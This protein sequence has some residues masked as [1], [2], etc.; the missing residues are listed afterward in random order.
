MRELK[1]RNAAMSKTVGALAACSLVLT[2]FA[3]SAFALEP[4][5]ISKFDGA[6]TINPQG[7]P[8][9]QA[10]SHPY[11]VSTEVKFSTQPDKVQPT[12]NVR[13]VDVELPAGLIGDPSAAPACTLEEFSAFPPS[14]IENS[15]I[16]TATIFSRGAELTTPIFNMVVPGDAPALFGFTV[17]VDPVTMTASVRPAEAEGDEGFGL[18]I[19]LANIS[20][21]VPITGTNL[22]FW[23]NPS[24]ARHDE[25]RGRCM[26]INHERQ[27]E[28]EREGIPIPREL[29]P[30]TA[31]PRPFMTLP[32]SCVGHPLVTHIH[33]QSWQGGEDSAQFATHGPAGESEPLQV[34]GCDQVPFA[35]SVE[36][37][38]NTPVADSPSGLTVDLK[39]PQNSE[40]KG[41]ATAHL[42]KTVVTLPSGISINPSTANG[43]VGCSEADFAQFSEAPTTCPQNSTIGTVQITTP[44]LGQPIKGSIFLAKQA[45]NPF[46]SLI[47]IFLVGETQGV[48]VKLPGEVALDPTSGRLVTTFDK[49][50]Q[51][52]FSDFKLNFF[53]GPSAVLATPATCG[54]Q[55]SSAVLTPWSA[56]GDVTGASSVTVSSGANGQPCAATPGARPFALGFEGGS[57]SNIA[58][59]YS[60]FSFKVT[61]PDGAQELSRIDGI[62][63]LGVLPTLRNVALCDDAHAASG[64]CS[65]GSR[66]GSVTAGVG[67]GTQPFFVRTGRAYLTGPYKGAPYGLDFV[68]PAVAGPLD[69]GTVN[70]RA[71]AF[72]DPETA[73]LTIKSDQFPTILDGI[74]L[75]I[76]SVEVNF[77]R[78]GFVRNPTSCDPTQVGALVTSTEGATTNLADRYQ[79]ANCQA[80]KFSP[81]LTPKLLGG[82]KAL[83]RRS[84]PGL[85][86]TLT[87]PKGQANLSSVQLQM[88]KSILLEQAHIRTVCT[89]VQ[90]AANACPKA[91]IYGHATAFTPLLGAPLTGPVYLRSSNNKLPD[92]VADLR[93]QIQIVLDGRIDSPKGKG[94]RTT[95]TGIP[96][97]PVTKFV[98]TMKGGAK[99]L[100]ANSVDLCASKA[101]STATVKTV[102]HNGATHKTAPSLATSCGGK[103]KKHG[104]HHQH[105]S[106]K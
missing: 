30:Y 28:E 3:S 33:A 47:A 82:R 55:A 7:D 104:K 90:F 69:L 83:Q 22:T 56:N 21:G 31:T 43:L 41:L 92:L 27:E 40:A 14:C 4:F 91:S 39:I 97:A 2:I 24:D 37:T 53:G 98:L 77:D 12:Q 73:Q 95:F 16:G 15:Q 26:S 42:K 89:R 25:E 76:R 38:V 36:T 61:R 5:A 99:S 10:G 51:V 11:A 68:L 71:A 17:I 103:H 62:A 86:V 105:K 13:N 46:H 72:V 1:T 52:P 106:H 65:E 101:A 57:L 44:L 102:G 84:H 88:P 45:E 29:C 66:V 87:Q 35:G 93:G 79:T 18:D 58:A 50:P 63:P 81:K 8:A 60:P 20:Q 100:L 49:T 96:D 9:T 59:A 78:K 54:S 85:Q 6:V 94:I 34:T 23:G 74:P 70:V 64:T 75:R 32:T 67:A 80:L 19:H 48:R